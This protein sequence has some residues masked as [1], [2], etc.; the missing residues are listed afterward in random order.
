MYRRAAGGLRHRGESHD[1]E[2]GENTTSSGQR[3]IA[4]RFNAAKKI[5]GIEA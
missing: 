2:G 1:V 4:R 3:R 5:R